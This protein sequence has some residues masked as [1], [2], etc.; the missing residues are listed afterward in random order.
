MRNNRLLLTLLLGLIPTANAGVYYYP[1]R[2][3]KVNCH[4]GLAYH[5]VEYKNGTTTLLKDHGDEKYQ[6][7]YL[8]MKFP[9]GR[10]A[11]ERYLACSYREITAEELSDVM[12]D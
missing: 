5:L 10:Y 8:E 11:N 1:D 6:Y 3:I 2:N 4:D 12:A 9:Y 7:P